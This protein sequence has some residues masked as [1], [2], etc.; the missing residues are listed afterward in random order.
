MPEF[1]ALNLL[2]IVLSPCSIALSVNQQA[3][4]AFAFEQIEN[5]NQSFN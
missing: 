4:A 2:P 5:I 1:K 3:A